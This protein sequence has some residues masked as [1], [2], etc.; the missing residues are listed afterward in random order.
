MGYEPESVEEEDRDN[1]IGYSRGFGG[2][3][4][5]LKGKVPIDGDCA[6]QG[7]RRNQEKEV[8]RR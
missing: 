3:Q 8:H 1:D 4:M 2:S 5:F 6:Q 7:E